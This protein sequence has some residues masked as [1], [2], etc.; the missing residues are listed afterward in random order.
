MV[1]SSNAW[2]AGADRF[3]VHTYLLEREQ[4]L[5]KPIDE[6]FAF[7]S[8]P[9][10]LQRITPA[11]LD[12]GMVETP[13][14]LR[15]GSLIRYRLRWHGVPVRWTT[16]ITEWNPPNGFVDRELSGPYALWNHEHRFA[17]QNGGTIMRDRVTYALPL[18]WIGRLAHGVLVKRDVERIFDFRNEAMK[19]LFG[20]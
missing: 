2:S 17:E 9:E 8:R 13:E 4:W 12:F 1:D 10:N 19:Q 5:P 11:W 14:K 18:G 3:P 6:I 15:V 20:S 7:F 16:E